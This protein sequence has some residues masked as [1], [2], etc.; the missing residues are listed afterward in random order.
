MVWP[1]TSEQYEKV[2]SI[3][4]YGEENQ[5]LFSGKKWGYEVTPDMKA[6][7]W[8]KLRIVENEAIGEHDDPLLRQVAGEGLLNL[9]A[10]KSADE[11]C[12]DYLKLLYTHVLGQIEEEWT[13]MITNDMRF[14]FVLTTPAGWADGAKD[15][16]RAAAESAGF[17][18]RPGD[19]IRMAD[20]P[21]AAAR[22]SFETGCG[23]PGAS[24]AFRVRCYTAYQVGGRGGYR[25]GERNLLQVRLV[26]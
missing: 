4:A 2:P 16:I 6:Y 24:N 7:S 1:G 5:A 10:G 13:G 23:R 12:G 15:R 18:S 17:G 11:V 3:I 21:E 8:F 20:E 19:S 14:S 9:P 22:Y 25:R 26:V